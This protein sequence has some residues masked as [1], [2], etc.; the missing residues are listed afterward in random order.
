MTSDRPSFD[1]T[2][3]RR[4]GCWR[5]A[6][7][8]GP[9]GTAYV[10]VQPPPSHQTHWC[11]SQHP[12]L[13]PAVAPMWQPRCASPSAPPF[14]SR[15]GRRS[16]RLFGSLG[17]EDGRGFGA[18]EPA[19]QIEATSTRRRQAQTLS[20]AV[21]D[22]T[23]A[24]SANTARGSHL[25]G[26]GGPQDQEADSLQAQITALQDRD[27]G[28]R[29]S[30]SRRSSPTRRTA[31]EGGAAL[32]RAPD[33]A[34]QP[35][36]AARQGRGQDRQQRP[37]GVVRERRDL[38]HPA[39]TAATGPSTCALLLGWPALGALVCT[40]WRSPSSSRRHVATRGCGFAT[41]SPT[42]SAARCWLRCGATT[43]V[44]GGLVDSA[45]DLRGDSSRVV[46]VPSGPAR[47]G[48]ADA[49]DSKAEPRAR[50]GRPSAVDDRGVAVR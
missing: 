10:M 46:G 39:A 18:D 23:S 9:G 13:R 41:R 33:R 4:R 29:R 37:G 50:E 43:T 22:A 24:T 11:C 17:R 34:G 16:S 35:R 30:G 31:G 5:R 38:G 27:H 44:G 6:V 25:G 32:A 45:R 1:A 20:Q 40:I 15:R 2:L 3:R 19:H 12:R 14:W 7:V 26:A 8:G 28:R 42:R 48:T 36:P 21:A 49:Q 47:S